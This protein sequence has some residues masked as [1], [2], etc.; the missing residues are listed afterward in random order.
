IGLTL[1]A[2]TVIAALVADPQLRESAV[3]PPA[4]FAAGALL[5]MG[6]AA[7]TTVVVLRTVSRV[8]NADPDTS[9]SLP[10]LHG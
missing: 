7:G 4:A 8:S 10:D 2:T 9:R 1:I 6:T 5:I 3:G